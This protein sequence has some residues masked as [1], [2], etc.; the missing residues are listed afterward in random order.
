MFYK[1]DILLLWVPNTIFCMCLCLYHSLAPVIFFAVVLLD[2]FHSMWCLFCVV[3]CGVMYTRTTCV[4]VFVRSIFVFTS[5]DCMK[6]VRYLTWMILS[7]RCT[8]TCTWRDVQNDIT[9]THSNTQKKERFQ[10]CRLYY[11][12][13]VK[14]NASSME[15]KST[16]W[17]TRKQKF[18]SSSQKWRVLVLVLPLSLLRTI[19][20]SSFFF[21]SLFW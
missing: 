10:R 12:F 5:I 20:L 15:K 13:S 3:W 17:H 1:F 2:S 16:H 8:S 18:T 6:I 9:L 4:C 14:S 7:S 21:H 11:Y 19:I